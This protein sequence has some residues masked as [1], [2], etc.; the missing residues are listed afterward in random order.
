L[1]PKKNGAPAFENN[2]GDVLVQHAAALSDTLCPECENYPE[3]S[4]IACEA[5]LIVQA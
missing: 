1:F 4:V 3:Q 2:F 5:F